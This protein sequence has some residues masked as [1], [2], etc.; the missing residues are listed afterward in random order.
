[1]KFNISS[2]YFIPIGIALY[3][4]FLIIGGVI[5]SAI[6]TVGFILFLLGLFDILRSWFKKGKS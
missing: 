6:G 5:G 3:I 4:I 2:K 1:M